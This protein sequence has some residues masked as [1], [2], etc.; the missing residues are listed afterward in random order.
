MVPFKISPNRNLGFLKTVLFDK[1]EQC[2]SAD[3]SQA[4]SK[5]GAKFFVF[6]FTTYSFGDNEDILLTICLFFKAFLNTIQV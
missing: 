4:P 3:V 5:C 6:T 1:L 2:F